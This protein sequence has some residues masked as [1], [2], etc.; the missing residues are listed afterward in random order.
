MET[1]KYISGNEQEKIAATI[2]KILQVCNT[3]D[4][5]LP[6]EY[7]I[8]QLYDWCLHNFKYNY[9]AREKFLKNDPTFNYKA[10]NNLDRLISENIGVCGQFTEAF[11]LMCTQIDG[12]HPYYILTK[13]KS[14][15]PCYNCNHA[16]CLLDINDKVSLV[17]VSFGLK[18][19][20]NKQNPY[21][22]LLK[23]WKDLQNTY[24]E[25]RNV[26]M[27]PTSIMVNTSRDI[28]N[29]YNYF[30]DI[31]S[32]IFANFSDVYIKSFLTNSYSTDIRKSK[33]EIFEE[34][35]REI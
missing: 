7:Q 5:T 32:E 26:V 6:I 25:K 2:N 19:V 8:K 10:E 11:C 35:G 23:S 14:N 4:R 17:D 21:D 13:A 3:V 1:E 9:S 12:V 15:D 22:Y 20:I 34:K 33:R 31:N 29:F 24:F 28:N 30:K 27:K 18:A 16:L